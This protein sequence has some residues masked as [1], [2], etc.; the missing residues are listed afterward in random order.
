MPE[1]SAGTGLTLLQ[2]LGLQLQPA[3]PD[4][5]RCERSVASCVTAAP[6]GRP[7]HT[8]AWPLPSPPQSFCRIATSVRV[9]LI[10]LCFCTVPWPCIFHSVYHPPHHDL[11]SLRAVSVPQLSAP[12]RVEAS[13]HQ[14]NLE[15]PGT[16]QVCR[17]CLLNEWGVTENGAGE[18]SRG[19]LG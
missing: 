19:G 10:P 16:Q 5:W 2:Q 13:V 18:G 12:M 9:Q 14:H 6:P 1:M 7:T 11:H 3:R 4:P 17:K 8:S 15:Q